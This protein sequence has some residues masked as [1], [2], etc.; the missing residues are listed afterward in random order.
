MSRTW[1][2]RPFT[3]NSPKLP[4]LRF[5]AA[6]LLACFI[7][8]RAFAQAPIEP[9]RIYIGNDDHTDYMWATD[10]DTYDGIF[11]EMLDFHLGLLQQTKNNPSAFRNRFNTD[12]SLWL[13]HYER[14]KSPADF[15][16]LIDAIKQG[17]ISSPLNTIVSCYGGQPVEAVL[18]GMYYA[19]RLERRH[20]LRFPLATATE[21][22]TLPLGL[23]SLFAGA[24]ATYTWRGVCGCANKI[25][26]HVLAARPREVYWYQGHD[27]QRLLMKW[28]SLARGQ[29]PVESGAGTPRK[30]HTPMVQRRDVGTYI[31]ARNPRMSIAYLENDAGFRARHVDPVSRQPYRIMGVFGFGGDALARKTGKPG[32]EPEIPGAPGIPHIPYFVEAEHFHVV[33]QQ[34]TTPHRQVIVSDIV[35]YFRDFEKTYGATLDTHT[36]TYGN[37]WDLYSASMAETS[38]RA[39]RAIEKLRAAEALGTF[40]ALK[41]PEFL[42]PRLLS[43]DEAFRDI[44]L[45]WE[46][47]WTADGQVTNGARA[48]WQAKIAQNIESYVDALHGDAKQRLAGMIAK[49]N[50][51]TQRFFV[52]NPLGWSR[53]DVADHV[54]RGPADIQVRDVTT[55]GIVPHQMVRIKGVPSIRILARDVPSVGYKTYEIT[56]LVAQSALTGGPMEADFAATVSGEGSEIIENSA[57]R[58]AVERDGAIRSFVDK[59][60]GNVELAGTHAGFHLNDLV[61]GS[62]GEPL[63]IVNRGPISV[64]LRARSNADLERAT[65]ITL[66]RDSE[67]VDIQNE[68]TAN[69]AD[70]R[71]W[72]FS[73]NLANPAVHTE[74]VGAINLNKLASDGGAY[75]N[76]HARYDYV[77]VNHFADISDG[78]GVRGMTISNPDLAFA[79][80]G[81]STFDKLDTAT[82]QINLLAGGQVDGARLG[83]KEQ[84]GATYFLQRFALR[85]HGGYDPVTAMRF[86]LEHQN[87]FV[88][89]AVLGSESAP[90]PETRYSLLTTDAPGVLL[91]TLKP[92]EEGL[93]HGLIARLWNVSSSSSTV[94]VKATPEIAAALRTTH[95]E[96]DLE[97]LTVDAGAVSLPFARQ[98]LQTVRLLLK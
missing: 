29:V 94:R 17:Y 37:E 83:V 52:F 21:N 88:V 65:E 61:A 48:A 98:Q 26:N 75:A 96:T 89:G 76:T 11:V 4:R 13:W 27:G 62:D 39:K 1:R 93:A 28:Y 95:I 64:T 60:R 35:D 47:N 31:E 44:G 45:Y 6:A 87:P 71:H 32:G 30:P 19:G 10:A 74:E 73:F 34:E 18:R 91:W 46:H 70:L 67:R 2:R 90:Y 66:Y 82:P 9:T 20:Q 23:A 36:V 22:Q 81:N 59:R 40:V 51:Q 72:T 3:V 68:I 49:P 79:R 86:A 84:N 57:V 58:L 38:A 85:P 54:Y 55:G 7:A 12:G 53:T 80:L 77:T 16:R 14:K 56:R 69:F 8:S 43:R 92:A 5:F 15:A 78:T 25:P 33:A 97:P 41:M 42:T 24:G 50:A 63:T